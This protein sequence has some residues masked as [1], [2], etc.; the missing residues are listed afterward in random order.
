[1]LRTADMILRKAMERYREKNQ[2]P[3]L[4]L[5]SDYFSQMTN[6]A[7]LGIQVA[8]DDESRPLLVGVRNPASSAVGSWMASDQAMPHPPKNSKKK[9]SPVGPLL[10]S[11]AELPGMDRVVPPSLPKL[12]EVAGMSDGTCDQLYLALRLASLQVWLATHEPIPLVVDDILMNFDDQRAVSTLQLLDRFASQ[13]QI[14]FF[15]HHQHT[16][17]LARQQLPP[18]R[19]HLHALG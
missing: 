14:L 19:F 13:T 10:P 16:L 11:P 1:M 6:R 9:P 3:I 5:A 4:E 17:E 2:S 18:E 15:T 12:V 8:F 7:F